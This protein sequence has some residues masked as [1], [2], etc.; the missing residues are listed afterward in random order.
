VRIKIPFGGFAA[1]FTA[2]KWRVAA[3]TKLCALTYRR[4]SDLAPNS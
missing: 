4:V 1:D 2:S 3:V